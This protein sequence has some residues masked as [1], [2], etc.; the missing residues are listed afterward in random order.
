MKR[1]YKKADV[2]GA[3]GGFCVHLDDRNI[4]TPGKAPLIV[5]LERLAVEIAAEWA[6]QGEEIKPA[7]MPMSRLANTVIDV[8]AP[9]RSEI[10]ANLGAYGETD[11]LCYR[12]ARPDDLAARQ[13]AGW[14]PLL[15]WAARHHEARLHATTGVG[16]LPQA[17]AALDALSGAVSGHD[18][19]ELAPLADFTTISGSLVLALAVSG[20]EIGW[21]RAWELSRLD[22]QY[23]NERWGE[24][25][26]AQARERRRRTELEEAA[27]FLALLR[28]G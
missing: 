25:P 27:R 23:Q 18:E 6:A 5:P 21:Q 26:E 24:D 4:R 16:H 28:G 12:A 22:E 9:R 7:S 11:L 3:Q 20:G 10:V 14:Q 15:D 1:F 19:W 17:R 2:A 8:V 13:A